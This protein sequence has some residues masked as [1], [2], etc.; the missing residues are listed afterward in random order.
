MLTENRRE[1]L[2]KRRTEKKKTKIEYDY[3][4][5][6]WLE[7]ILDHGEEG[8]I[9]D[10][11]RVLDTLDREAIRKHL[12]D[13][14]VDD[15][16]KLVE[17]LL[18]ILDFMPV[19]YDKEGTPFVSKAI[20]VAPS[21]GGT[22]GKTMS[23]RK[24]TD[25]DLKRVEMLKAHIDYLQHFLEAKSFDSDPRSAEY[26]RELIDDAHKHGLIAIAYERIGP[27]DK[28]EESEEKGEKP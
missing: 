18:E 9:G 26:Y 25:N 20:L 24:V 16:L 21:G 12:K 2:R 8:G 10:I 13:E 15:L 7:T 22:V 11:N 17:R 6:K 14:N 27:E 1:F 3:R 23:V 28:K 4:I 5:L 19:N